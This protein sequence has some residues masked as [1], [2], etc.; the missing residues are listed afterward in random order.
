MSK[1]LF[2]I[3]GL[4]VLTV[5]SACKK[6]DDNPPATTPAD[7]VPTPT[8]AD[9]VCVSI[10][11]SSVITIPGFGDQTTFLGLA[12]AFFPVSGNTSSFNDAGTVS[13]NTIGL[14]KQSNNSYMFQPSQTNAS[15]DFDSSNDWSI[16][17]SGN[18]PAF[19]Y[20]NSTAIP[21]IGNLTAGS[22]VNIGSDLTLGV[23]LTNS[24]TALNNPDS[25]YFGVYGTSGSVIVSK[26]GN[27]TSYTFTAAE[28][29]GVGTGSGFVQI[30]AM[31]FNPQTLSG[32]KIYFINEGVF[33]KQVTLQ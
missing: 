13:V 4:S 14:T 26:P 16:G 18:V 30:A 17:G 2:F 3:L 11:S 12:S 25:I 8:D 6:E 28:M 23:D 5:F 10:K 15:I 19:N 20:S 29:S 32:K 7:P 24:A 31:K 21:K 1:N 33:T 9:G 22:T 27:I